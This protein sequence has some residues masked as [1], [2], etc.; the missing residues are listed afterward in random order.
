MNLPSKVKLTKRETDY[1]QWYLDV[2]KSGALYE[3]SPTPGCISFLPKA[4][5]I[6]EK[7]KFETNARLEILGV[8]NVLLP[9]LIPIDFFSLEG[10]FV[11][12]FAPEFAVVT[13]GGGVE[14]EKKLVFRPTSEMMFCEFF[15]KRLQSYRDLP[16]LYNQWCNCI[17]WEK[18]PRPFLRTMEF[19]WQEG[20]TLHEDKD[21]ALQFATDILNDVYISV[22]NECLAIDGIRGYKPESEK[23]AGADITMTYEP[24]MSNGWALQICTSHVLGKGFTSAFDLNFLDR[25]GNKAVPAY[26][27]WGMST[28][29]IGGMISTHSDNKGLVIP[30]NASEYAATLLPIMFSDPK[31]AEYT[32]KIT[33]TLSAIR[34]KNQSTDG[35]CELRSHTHKYLL[36]QRD[37]RIGEKMFDWELSG[38]PIAVKFGPSEAD[39]NSVLL[40]SRHNGVAKEVLLDNLEAELSLCLASM[41]ADLFKASGDRMRQ[42]SI[43]CQTPSDVIEVVKNGKFA[44]Y[45]WDGSVDFEKLIKDQASATIRCIPFQDSW[46]HE[47]VPPS[48][49]SSSK[50]VVIAKAF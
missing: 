8:K 11:K 37:I 3:T 36:D 46:V 23:F 49:D 38:Y 22:I 32:S 16:M 1:A 13:H 10:D 18:R 44:L 28:R 15:S 24:M 42:N 45:S 20:H 7:I 4:V 34:L 29:T 17:R 35:V 27:S 50:T 40:V 5:S 6:W 48:S 12:G 26:T 47:I 39:K 25:N 33:K 2:A 9:T 21:S 19:H 31:V 41:H 30:P 43:A 14:L